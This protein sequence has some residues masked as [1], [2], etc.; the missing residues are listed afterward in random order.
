MPA[1]LLLVAALTLAPTYKINTVKTLKRGYYSTSLSM[2]IFSGSPLAD[3]VTKNVDATTRAAL[4]GWLKESFSG[5]EAN[6]KP[7]LEYFYTTAPTVSL[8]TPNIISFYY[9]TS[10]F[11]A[12]AHPMTVFE[13]H[14]YVM[15]N[16]RAK[17]VRFADIFASGVNAPTVVSN[18]VIGQLMTNDRAEWVQNG[19]VKELTAAQLDSFVVTPTA[20]T[21]LFNPYDMG[22]YAVGSFQVKVPFADMKAVINGNGALK[23]LL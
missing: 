12:G 15:S 9:T 16:G 17:E 21:Y 1:A 11:T 3:Q 8:N 23:S 13:P 18:L 10:T 4:A 22:P 5:P 19:Q 2:P 14:T 7:R 20:L 6:Q